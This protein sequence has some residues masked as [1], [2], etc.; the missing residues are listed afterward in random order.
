MSYW[1]RQQQP[2]PEVVL[3]GI[4]L[5]RASHFRALGQEYWRGRGVS[6][7]YTASNNLERLQRLLHE[8]GQEKDV[9]YEDSDDEEEEEQ[10][11]NGIILEAKT[12]YRSWTED[13]KIP[14]HE[15]ILPRW[16]GTLMFLY[17]VYII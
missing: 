6:S 7:W 17:G 8:K 5:I 4:P 13:D 3:G 16:E 9:S 12:K 10:R 11:I 2:Q 15:D 14:Y 1:Q